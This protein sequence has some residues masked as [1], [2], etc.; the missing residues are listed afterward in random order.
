MVEKVET[1]LSDIFKG[2][3]SRIVNRLRNILTSQN[4]TNMR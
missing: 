4:R 1:E 2:P 3:S